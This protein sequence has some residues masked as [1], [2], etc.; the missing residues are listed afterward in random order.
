VSVI[1]AVVF[2]MD[3]VLIDSEPVWERVRRGFVAERG[4]SWPPGAQDAMMGMSTGEWSAY[5][6]TDFDLRVRLAPSE[7]AD[8]V[9][10]AMKAQYAEH[11]PLLPGAVETVRALAARW[12]LAVAS[13]APQALI[14]TV[15]D[16]A[17][18]RPA[19]RAAVSSELVP[20]G[21]PA[22][23]VYL[24]AVSRLGV[25]PSACAAIEDSSN[26][27]RSAAAAGMTVIAVPRPEYPPAADAMAGASVVLGSLTELTPE[28]IASLS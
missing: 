23:D 9:I 19:F 27:L 11:L 14:E 2:D 3:G 28:V 24:E 16:A 20:R 4:G 13:S 22:P 25:K 21:K 10:T 12:P 1:E 7:V 18:L 26:G 5:I 8:L 15:L 17:D 6:A